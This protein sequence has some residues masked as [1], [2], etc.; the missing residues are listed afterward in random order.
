MTTGA[1]EELDFDPDALRDKYRRERDRRIRPDGTAQYR[2]A[3]GEFGYYAHDPYTPRTD[4]EPLDDRVEV[5]V[6]GGGFGGL[7]TGARL[8]E[9]GIESLRMMDEAG[10]FGGTWY[11]NRYPGIH[12]DIESYVYMPLLE[13]IGHMPN[14]RYAPGE[15]IRRHAVAIADHYDLYRDTAFHTRAT[16]LR[17]DENEEEWLVSTDRGDSMRARYVIVSSGTLTQPKLPGIP[18]IEGFR[19]HTFHTSRWDYGYTGGDADGGLLGLADK[20]VGV[21]G[22][23]A[24]GLQAIPQIAR[25]AQQLLVFQRTPS[26][27]DVRDNRPTDPEWAAGLKP[28]WQRERMDNFLSILSGEDVSEDLTQDGWT[29]TARLQRK[30]ITGAVDTTLDE[31]ERERRDE[32]ADF[33]KMEQI[34]ARVDEVVT[35]PQTAES[36][37]PW[38]RYMCKRPGFSD[39]YLQAFNRPNVTL[40]DTADHG[41]VTRMTETAVVVG[42]EEFDVDCVIFATGFEAGVSGVVSGSLPVHGR[43]GLRLLDHWA[44]GPRTLHGFYSHGFPNLFHL[45]SMQNANSVNFVHIL[46]EQAEHI[47]AVVAAARD[48]GARY[49][50]PTA[51][52]EQ[53]WCET[54]AEVA[55][56]TSSFLAEC[57]PGYYN[58]EGTRTASATSYSPG[59]IA[60]HRLLNQWRAQNL[61]DVLVTHDDAES[62]VA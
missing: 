30:M 45:G 3:S 28:G 42:D 53:D 51:E 15:E 43:D 18:G 12:C 39:Q 41:G 37:K 31:D 29:S 60:F 9:A 38:Y 61:H 46:T 54:L 58:G 14:W 47:A 25:D 22:T 44:K 10:D 57:T 1:R 7:V 56:D 24:T 6:I 36:L 27:V 55:V 34:R 20:K 49:V 5:L 16:Q 40:V 11:W 26:S 17:W 48:A 2:G 23:G 32:L 62:A 50:E 52:A 8:R 21:I 33:A 4:R 19:G 59:P 35:D 13:E